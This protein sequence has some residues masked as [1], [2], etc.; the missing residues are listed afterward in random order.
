[1]QLPLANFK[2]WLPAVCAIVLARLADSSLRFEEPFRVAAAVAVVVVV[3]VVVVAAAV[4][5][6]V[7]VVVASFVLESG[8][9]KKIN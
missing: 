3:V 5:V 4:A 1:M 9:L 2:N 8:H 7:V 6:V